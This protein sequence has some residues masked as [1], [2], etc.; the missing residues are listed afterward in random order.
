VAID[1]FTKFAFLKAVRNTKV[2]PVLKFLDEIINMFG[3]T[4]RIICD[5]GSCFTS[6]CF[7]E[8]CNAINIKVNY[9][10]TATPRA[11]G[12]AE[13]YDRTILNASST[14]T[15]DERKW[16]EGVKNI[17][18]GLNTS[19][20]KTT[21]KTP[22]ELLLGYRP[23]QAN[24]SFLSAE[25]CD[26][27]YDEHLSVTRERASE[28]IREKQAEQ[29]SRYGLSRRPTPACY[30]GQ[31]VLVRKAVPTND[32]KSKKLLQKYSGPY[33]IKKILDCDRFIIS[34]LKGTTRSQ[35]PYE[36]VVSLDKRIIWLLVLTSIAV[37]TTMSKLIVEHV[38]YFSVVILL[39]DCI[40]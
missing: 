31:Q 37:V 33:V 13:S 14:S 5:R 1:G 38:Y 2:G 25:V 28:R 23:R 30:V 17:Q 19:L 16:D 11:N 40:L 21:G 34:D 29:N 27:Q 6:K 9:N 36:G 4:Q 35:R 24:D 18:W 8:Y 12:Q 32:G 39:L 3:V 15:D 20:N 7:N 10:A 26:T 22:Y